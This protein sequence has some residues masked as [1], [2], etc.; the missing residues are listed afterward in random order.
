MLNAYLFQL[1]A[2]H[3][4]VL[5][6]FYIWLCSLQACNNNNNNNNDN[7]NINNNVASIAAFVL[8]LYGTKF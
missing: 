7:N 6:G 5:H 3:W 2:L 4:L 8:V 1:Y